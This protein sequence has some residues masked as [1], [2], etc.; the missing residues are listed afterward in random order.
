[1]RL[2]PCSAERAAFA[3]LIHQPSSFPF[4][5]LHT[6]SESSARTLCLSPMNS[7]S[8]GCQRTEGSPTV[9]VEFAMRDFGGIGDGSEVAEP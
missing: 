9:L 5:S 8:S 6:A 2:E 7:T 3:S 1:M 4:S